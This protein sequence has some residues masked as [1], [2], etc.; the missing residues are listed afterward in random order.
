MRRQIEN[1][2]EIGKQ[3][4]EKKN[5]EKER[6]RI[7]ITGGSRIGSVEVGKEK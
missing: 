5:V 1:E 6:R 3:W 7:K 2:F 4:R